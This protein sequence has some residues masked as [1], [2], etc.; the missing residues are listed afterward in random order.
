MAKKAIRPIRIEGN[1][2][3][4]TL[5]KGYVAILD[6]NDVPLVSGWNWSALVKKTTV[7]AVRKLGSRGE[8]AVYMHRAILPVAAGQLVD[9]I[10]GNG[11]NN[12]RENLRSASH[13]Q[14]CRNQRRCTRNT[15]G[16][17]GVTWCARRRKWRAQ[18][19]ADGKRHDLGFFP[20][21]EEAHAAYAEASARLHGCF[22]RTA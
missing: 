6:A 5:T 11:L 13:V 21:P 22:G 8:A 20:S 19:A 3:Y 9:H 7:Y 10:D 2:A 4:V 15:S 12:R 16:F 17:K 1:I 18:I 14:N